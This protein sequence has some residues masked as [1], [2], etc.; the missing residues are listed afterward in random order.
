[1]IKEIFRQFL[2]HALG[3]RGNK[4]TFVL[5]RTY[6][7][8]LQKIIYLVFRRTHLYLWVKES[9]G[10]YHL[11]HHHA[12]CCIQFVFRRGCRDIY[13][14]IQHLLKLLKPQRTIVKCGRQSETVLHKILLSA[15]V[16]TIHSPYLGYGDVALI[17]HHEEILGEEVKQAIRSL[18][19]SPA[20]KIS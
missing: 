12:L 8:F 17:Y 20:V 2:R 9:R 16:T 7:Y 10:A 1:M 15:P 3:K 6:T 14:L 5:L 11:F 4:N 18:A 19:W 13:D